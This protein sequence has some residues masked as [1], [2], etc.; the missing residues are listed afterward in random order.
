[1]HVCGH[2]NKI[3][4][5]LYFSHLI[6]HQMWILFL[7]FISTLNVHLPPNCEVEIFP[8]H[9]FNDSVERFR[10]AV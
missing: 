4:L 1:M 7:L 10:D 9:I 2:Y 8:R 6:P 3:L 5:R